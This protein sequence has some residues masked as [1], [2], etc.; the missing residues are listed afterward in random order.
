[1]ATAT[2]SGKWAKSDVT[3]VKIQKEP[4]MLETS[5][6]ECI[7]FKDGPV[8]WNKK[9][10]NLSKFIMSAI[11]NFWVRKIDSFF[12]VLNGELTEV[13]QILLVECTVLNKRKL[14]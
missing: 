9:I 4:H 14:L 12:A 7:L 8:H 2:L 5:N 13:S 1:M 10:S 11:M 3:L 6:F